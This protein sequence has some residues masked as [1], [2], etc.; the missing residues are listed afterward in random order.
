[1]KIS[2][3]IPVLDEE[4]TIAKILDYLLEI[5]DPAFTNEII[6]VDGGSQDT[7]LEILKNYPSIKVIHSH[8]GRAIQ[9]NLGEKNA[10]SDIL[11]FLHCD[12]LPPKN[13]DAEIVNKVKNGYL[14]GCFKMKFDHHHIVLKA[15]QWFTRFNV[16]CCRGGDQSL[17]V[18][19]KLF[20]KLNGFNEQLII[21]EDNELISRLYKNSKFTV[22]QKTVITSARKYLK[23]GVWKLQFH[24]GMIHCKFWF[25]L[26]Q[27]ELIAYYQKHIK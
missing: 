10:S 15:S 16:R 2:I 26:N 18:E 21:Y 11:Y 4:K 6:I 14:S 22:I 1:M 5:L 25:G 20:E 23:N 3:I 12:T 13:F 27:E 9:M 8:K 24:F 17:F 19:R 7:T